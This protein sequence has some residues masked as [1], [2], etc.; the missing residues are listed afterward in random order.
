MAPVTPQNVNRLAKALML[1]HQVPYERAVEMLGALTLHI[2]CGDGVSV[3][4]AR[5]AAVLTAVNT[6]KRAFRG[7][8]TITVPD[9]ISLRVPS[10]GAVT[11]KEAAIGL[12]ATAADTPGASA[13]VVIGDSTASLPGLHVICDGWRG[14]VVPACC[15]DV[16][17]ITGPDFALGGVFAGGFA[18]ARAFLSATHIHNR[19]VVEPT[20][21]SIWRPELPWGDP[22]ACG[23]ELIHLPAKLWLL[24][25]GHL[26]QAYCWTLGLLPMRKEHPVEVFLQDYDRVEEGNFSAGLLCELAEIT[27]KKTRVS[28]KWLDDRGFETI[29]LERPFD[30]HTIRGVDEPRVALC[31]FDNAESRMCLE[32][33]GF[34]LIVDCGLGASLD[35]FDRIVLQTFPDAS[36]KA[37]EV[38]SQPTAQPKETALDFGAVGEP[39]C[40]IVFEEIA[41]KAISSAFTG[42][43]ASAMAIGEVLRAI[44][45]GRRCE[46]LNLH[47][48]DLTLPTSPYREEPYQLRVVRNGLVPVA[49]NA[50]VAPAAGVVEIACVS[51]S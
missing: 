33:V 40:G 9:G 24:G 13:T 8:V 15:H 47:L 16:P 34:E 14:G 49:E 31:G 2:I 50:H 46:F 43:C 1:R 51:N 38:Y 7:G 39:E 25:L 20:G 10:H 29:I 42:A 17:A 32:E 26:G 36:R 41:G 4:A 3:S 28:A 45:G 19:E 23:P 37:R 21:F 18:V 22:E 44:H 6:G 30:Q 35:R 27:R 12:G 5:Q 48:R 11:L